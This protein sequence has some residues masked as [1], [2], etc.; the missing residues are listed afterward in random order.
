MPVRVGSDWQAE[1][2]VPR[3]GA[4]GFDA[5]TVWGNEVVGAADAGAEDR[6]AT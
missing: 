1:T 3:S 6:I 4:A 2:N 5:A